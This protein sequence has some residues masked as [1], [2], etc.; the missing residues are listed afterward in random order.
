V[1]T[2][3]APAKAAIEINFDSFTDALTHP[4]QRPEPF[5]GKGSYRSLPTA[6]DI[7]ELARRGVRFA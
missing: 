6:K 1:S 3:P 7:A 4:E 2:V 5:P